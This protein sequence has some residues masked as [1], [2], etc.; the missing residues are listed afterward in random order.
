MTDVFKAALAALHFAG[1]L[2]IG[3]IVWLIIGDPA[4][5]VGLHWALSEYIGAVG[6]A[7][8]QILTMALFAILGIFAVAATHGVIPLGK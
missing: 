1:T 3:A 2:A 7:V 4:S 5:P 6:P 8:G